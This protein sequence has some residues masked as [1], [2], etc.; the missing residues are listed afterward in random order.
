MAENGSSPGTDCP[1]AILVD[2]EPQ[3]K[4][5]NR[6]KLDFRL[7]LCESSAWTSLPGLGLIRQQLHSDH[8]QINTVSNKIKQSIVNSIYAGIFYIAI[9]Y[10]TRIIGGQGVSEEKPPPGEKFL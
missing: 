8:R 2:L 1:N 6:S 5:E 10:S 4:R 3:L 9:Q 7:I